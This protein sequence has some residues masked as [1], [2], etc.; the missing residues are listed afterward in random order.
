[1]APVL[2]GNPELRWL[3]FT[4]IRSDPVASRQFEGNNFAITQLRWHQLLV[5]YKFKFITVASVG[6]MADRAFSSEGC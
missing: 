6:E 4:D 3:A 2:N 1:M 5:I